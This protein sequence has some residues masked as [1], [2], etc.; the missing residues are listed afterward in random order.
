[1]ADSAR[2]FTLYGVD[3]PLVAP[4]DFELG[5]LVDCE[6]LFGARF[7]EDELDSRRLASILYVS[8]RRVEPTFTLAN[9]R[10]LGRDERAEINASIAA[11]AKEDDE[12]AD[13][14]NGEAPKS[15]DSPIERNSD[16]ERGSSRENDSAD[17]AG[18][19][20]RSSLQSSDS[21]HPTVIA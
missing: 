10:K 11:W 14:Q 5:E 2:T 9:L 18:S 1:M 19:G 16:D 21:V 6:N 15:D 7:D 3:Y 8:V 17:Q 20:H 13:P 12:P 4:N